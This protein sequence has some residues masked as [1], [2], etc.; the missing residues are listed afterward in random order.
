MFVSEK[1]ANLG[2]LLVHAGHPE[3]GLPLIERAVAGYD[4]LEVTPRTALIAQMNQAIGLSSLGRNEEAL[5]VAELAVEWMERQRDPNLAQGL[6]TVGVLYERAGNF[7]AALALA[8]RAIEARGGDVDDP[9]LALGR[10]RRGSILMRMGRH[11]EAYAA[12]STAHATVQ[13]KLG[14]EDRRTTTIVIWLGQALRLLGRLD[15][16]RAVLGDLVATHPPE[17]RS[18]SLAEAE[19]FL[20]WAE[21]SAGE[22]EAV[23]A[24]ADEAVERCPTCDSDLVRIAGAVAAFELGEDPATL[25]SVDLD[26]RDDL[27]PY[28]LHAE[29]KRVEKLRAAIAASEGASTARRR[30]HPP[31]PG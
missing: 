30:S 29:L 26:V 7:E 23:R 4:G 9:G 22:L 1:L 25:A 19:A 21:L 14:A 13:E 28:L 8:D 27:R 31:S 15:E 18:E 5:G 11:E 3:E 10:A 16:A 2:A 24:R 6:E 12:L 17:A 20:A